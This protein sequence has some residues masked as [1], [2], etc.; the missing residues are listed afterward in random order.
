MDTGFD[1][2]KLDDL[3]DQEQRRLRDRVRSYVERDV[4]PHI[5]SYWERAEFPREMA[6]AIKDLGIVGGVLQGHGCAG[7]DPLALGLAAAE[8][9]RGDG[10]ISTFYVVHSGLAM[11][12]I[13]LLGSEEEQRRW[14]PAM[15]V[16]DKIGALA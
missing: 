8:L 3:L 14:L 15:A 2:Y 9:S 6:L 12:S 13:G 16:L 10:S 11:G 5:N 1:F 4:L 7:L